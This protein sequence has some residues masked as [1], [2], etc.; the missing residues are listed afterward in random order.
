MNQQE[1]NNLMRD[2]KIL[3]VDDTE[4]NVQLTKIYLKRTGIE[5]KYIVVAIDW[6]DAVEKSK[7]NLF[8]LIIM[9]VNLPWIN[10]S[11]ASKII[12]SNPKTSQIPIIG[13]TA[14]DR[15]IDTENVFDGVI[16]RP[17]NKEVFSARILE[18]LNGQ[19][20]KN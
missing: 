8:D 3:V 20:I 17:T 11:E 9:D 6:L 10:W 18:M 16:I 7:Q 12:K 5:G 15:Y 13:Y 14:A 1:K 2:K 4:I 19:D